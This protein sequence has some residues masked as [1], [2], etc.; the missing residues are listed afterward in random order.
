MDWKYAVSNVPQ[1]NGKTGGEQIMHRVSKWRLFTTT[2]DKNN[3]K[4]FSCPK[5]IFPSPLFPLSQCCI[6][7]KSHQCT[8]KDSPASS[9][10]EKVEGKGRGGGFVQKFCVIF[11]KIFCP[12]L[13]MIYIVNAKITEVKVK[14]RFIILH[15]LWSADLST[16]FSQL[17]VSIFIFPQHFFSIDFAQWKSVGL[18]HIAYTVI[19]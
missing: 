16:S 7:P 12:R 19:H 3:E 1:S 15:Y 2:M 13:Q 18:P 5:K 10:I 17:I 8:S 6:N 14:S 11:L 4:I 9:N